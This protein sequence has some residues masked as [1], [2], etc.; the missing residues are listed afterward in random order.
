V[1]R[2]RFVISLAVTPLTYL[3]IALTLALLP[4]DREDPPHSDIDFDVL[5]LEGEWESPGI[6]EYYTARDGGELFLRHFPSD[7]RSIVILMHGSGTEGR[8]LVGLAHK[9]SASGGARVIVPDLR[10]HGRSGLTRMGDV[11]YLGQSEDDLHDLNAYLRSRFPE[12]RIIVGGHSSMGGLAVKYGGRS[13]LL[14]FDGY[15]L[16][17]PYLGHKAPTVRPN[18]GDWVQV[19][20]KRYAG[21]AMLNQIGITRLNGLPVLFFNRPPEVNDPLQA[22]SYSYRLSESLEPHQYSENLQ[23]N[24]SPMLVLVG[25]DDEAFYV[26]E[27]EPLFSQYAPHARLA[28][29]SGVTHLDLLDSEKAYQEISQW[30]AATS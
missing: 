5:D 16:L 10:G 29:L 26:D 8:Y 9:L 23:A 28:I 18:S 12:S 7:A 13:D 30:L 21:L 11:D 6:E 1:K 19:A 2:K 4:V 27:F 14:P 15:L 3:L 24:K 25:R 20:M 17:A 22:E